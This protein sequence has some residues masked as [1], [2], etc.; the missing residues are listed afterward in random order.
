M[1]YNQVFIQTL[2]ELMQ[3]HEL[4]IL[5]LSKK[6]NCNNSVISRWL[7]GFNNPKSYMLIRIADF[8]DCSIDYLYGR[9]DDP[10]FQKAKR[11]KT[12][13]EQLSMIMG[14]E[15]ITKYQLAKRCEIQPS[16]IS[17]WLI[18][19]RIPETETLLK[20]ADVLECSLDYL[21]GRT[22]FE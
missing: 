9:R 21:V 22:L 18:H 6:L 5:Q 19:S 15:K 12:F 7:T 2:Q 10:T 4:N 13:A 16:T 11:N 17:K 14:K 1:N 8:F 20:L 3:D